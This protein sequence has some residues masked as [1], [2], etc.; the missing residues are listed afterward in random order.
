V[1]QVQHF[2]VKDLRTTVYSLIMTLPVTWALDRHARDVITPISGDSITV[3][4]A[5]GRS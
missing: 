1:S 4:R 5:G 2:T 3:M